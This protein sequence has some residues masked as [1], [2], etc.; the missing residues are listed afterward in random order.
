MEV[1]ETKRVLRGVQM[2]IDE[3]LVFY[4][5]LIR[6]FR[7]WTNFRFY[8]SYVYFSSYMSTSPLIHSI[9]LH[10]LN[11]SIPNNYW[12]KTI[13]TL[14][15]SFLAVLPS[16]RFLFSSL[17]L[18]YSLYCIFPMSF[19]PSV[20]SHSSITCLLSFYI[21][22]IFFL[23]L[24]SSIPLLWSH[25]HIWIL[26]IFFYPS[27]S[28]SLLSTLV[29]FLWLYFCSVY[30]IWI[31]LPFPPLFCFSLSTFFYNLVCFYNLLLSCFYLRPSLSHLF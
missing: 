21:V 20:I 27:T 16:C 18:L 1:G 31:P 14:G 11:Y 9:L 29:I 19:G 17:L 26:P 7:L 22:C 23:P 3:D 4:C 6:A 10:S 15:F 25:F 5:C 30:Y 12:L 13:A 8:I 2:Y 28:S 24:L